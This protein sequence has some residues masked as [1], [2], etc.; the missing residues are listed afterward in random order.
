MYDLHYFGNIQYH[1]LINKNTNVNFSFNHFFQKGWFNN[2]TIIT[3]ANKN[4]ILSVPL[5]GGRNQKILLKDVKICYTN[6]WHLQHIKSIKSCYGNAPF[7][8]YYFP[9]IED[10]IKKKYSFLHE[11]NFASISCIYEILKSNKN[12]KLLQENLDTLEGTKSYF[13]M[14]ELNF[15]PVK[16]NQ[17]FEDKNGFFKNLSIL[18]LVFCVGPN[19]QKLL[20]M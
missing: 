16:Y 14:N 19:T 20:K 8:E 4:I 10:V 17:V 13:R 18:D 3:G 11:L 2:K 12:F 1:Q 5:L 15:A 9:K 7:F 6:P